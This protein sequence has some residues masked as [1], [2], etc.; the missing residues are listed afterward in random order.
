MNKKDYSYLISNPLK[1][2]M[3]NDIYNCFAVGFRIVSDYLEYVVAT[4]EYKMDELACT[5]PELIGA[6]LL[7]AY[8]K[9]MGRLINLKGLKMQSP[10]IDN[11]QTFFE[12]INHFNRK[13]AN[14]CLNKNLINEPQAVKILI[15]EFDRFSDDIHKIIPTYKGIRY[16]HTHIFPLFQNII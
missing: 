7:D 12:G 13:L 14:P 10:S 6:N 1:E 5:P 3:P 16:E 15:T 11:L 4:G 2:V 8:C 9:F